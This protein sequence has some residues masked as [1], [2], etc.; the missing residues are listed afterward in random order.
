MDTSE[1]G[2]ILIVDDQPANLGVLSDCFSDSG[3][4]ILVA[5]DGMSA[6]EKAEYVHPDIAFLALLRYTLVQAYQF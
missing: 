5:Q 4:E 3:F 2:T 1:K 6:I